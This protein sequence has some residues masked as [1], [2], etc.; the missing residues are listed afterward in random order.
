MFVTLP[1]AGVICIGA[2]KDIV[3]KS[4]AGKGN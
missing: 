1:E 2:S 3:E 4:A